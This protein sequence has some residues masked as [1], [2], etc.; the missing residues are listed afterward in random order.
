LFLHRGGY[1]SKGINDAP[2]G[3]LTALSVSGPLDLSL[4]PILAVHFLLGMAQPRPI[5]SAPGETLGQ[6]RA[7]PP[8]AQHQPPPTF[9]SPCCLLHPSNPPPSFAEHGRR[10]ASL[11]LSLNPFCSSTNSWS[12]RRLPIFRTNSSRR[13][14]RDEAQAAAH[15]PTHLAACS[16]AA[17]CRRREERGWWP[18]DAEQSAAR[19]AAARHALPGEQL[20]DL[21]GLRGLLPFRREQGSR[22]LRPLRHCRRSLRG[23]LPSRREQGSS[24]LALL[25]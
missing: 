20:L 2:I 7:H 25:C 8:S 23:L 11:D 24:V 13:H 3:G 5:K 19:T 1:A 15:A 9:L 17:F 16:A 14:R 6:S 21:C 12:T 10:R 22:V 4:Q 18:A